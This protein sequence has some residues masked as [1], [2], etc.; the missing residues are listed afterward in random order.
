MSKK[1]FVENR[2]NAFQKRARTTW[3][4]DSYNCVTSKQLV[5]KINFVPYLGEAKIHKQ[6]NP[7]TGKSDTKPTLLICE[8]Y[9]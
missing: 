6:T 9:I 8:T 2:K 4:H 1:E 7:Q 3:K 5:D